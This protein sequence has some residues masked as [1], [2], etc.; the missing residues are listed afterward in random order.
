MVTQLLTVCL[1]N[2]CR[3]PTAAAALDAAAAANDLEVEVA[4]AGTGAWH[5]GSP[6]D[7]RMR[8][9]ASARGLTLTG[10]AELATAEAIAHADLVLA[11]DADNLR[12]L[13]AVAADHELTTPIVRFRTFDP[14]ADPTVPD[15]LDV[16]DPYYG[17]PDGFDEVVELCRRSADAL[18]AQLAAGTPVDGLD[19]HLDPLERPRR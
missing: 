7:A 12:A 10:T 9:A 17:G 13:Q 14:L 15:D 8:Q 6:P 2:I 16:P 1:G 18:V 19:R 4:S 11:M 3:S 5:L